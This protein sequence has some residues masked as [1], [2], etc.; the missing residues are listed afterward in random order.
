MN[1]SRLVQQDI[2][3][4]GAFCQF[5]ASRVSLVSSKKRRADDL[6]GPSCLSHI[7]TKP[8]VG[9]QNGDSYGCQAGHRTSSVWSHTCMDINQ[10]SQKSCLTDYLCGLSDLRKDFPV[11]LESGNI[12]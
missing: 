11:G 2:L 4:G 9:G 12:V 10:T 1:S 6:P 8:D 5:R 7:A 3:V